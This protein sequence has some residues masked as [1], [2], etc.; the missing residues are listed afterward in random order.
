MK[1]DALSAVCGALAI[2]AAGFAVLQWR[3]E[4]A[5]TRIETAVPVSAAPPATEALAATLSRLAPPQDEPEAVTARPAPQLRLRLIGIVEND[6]GR[7]AVLELEGET[8]FLR[9]GEAA[10]GVSMIALDSSL[11]VV[12]TQGVERR[13][14]LGG[15]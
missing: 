11:A 8:L 12:R 3:A 2:A 9:P 1:L 10:A 4:P 13:L 6:E 7:V 5:Q 15:G 14:S